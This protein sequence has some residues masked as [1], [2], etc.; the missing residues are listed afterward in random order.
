M[1]KFKDKIKNI[2]KKNR[3]QDTKWRR[4]RAEGINPPANVE[5]NQ[6]RAKAAHGY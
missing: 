4:L 2:N 3:I 5:E 6:A 1:L